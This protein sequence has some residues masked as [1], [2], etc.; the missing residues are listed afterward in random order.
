MVFDTI[1]LLAWLQTVSLL[2]VH[3]VYESKNQ[4]LPSK[5]LWRFS[6]LGMLHSKLPE[7][8]KQP[9]ANSMALL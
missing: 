4:F 3:F 1:L 7:V 2:S 6:S 8:Q 5:F 9:Q